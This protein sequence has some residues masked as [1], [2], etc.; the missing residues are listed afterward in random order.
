M[1]LKEVSGPIWA[2]AIAGRVW[3]FELANAPDRRELCRQF[4]H[5]LAAPGWLR[6]RV[7][8]AQYATLA[9]L[10]QVETIEPILI[11]KRD[12]RPWVL[13]PGGLARCFE[14]APA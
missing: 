13:L 6:A 14:V 12:R 9:E 11:A 2:E 1:W 7:G 3:S 5:R 4:E 8:T 10:R